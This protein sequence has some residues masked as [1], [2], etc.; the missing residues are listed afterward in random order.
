MLQNW[1]SK[2]TFEQK[3]W[4]SNLKWKVF[5]L[6]TVLM[7]HFCQPAVGFSVVF[8][9]NTRLLSSCSLSL[10]VL[11]VAVNHSSGWDDTDISLWKKNCPKVLQQEQR[12][13]AREA[14]GK[15][16]CL[17]NC[18]DTPLRI[19]SLCSSLRSFTTQKMNNIIFC[20][21]RTLDCSVDAQCAQKVFKYAESELRIFR[22]KKSLFFS[23]FYWFLCRHS[24]YFSIF[25]WF[26][27]RHRIIVNKFA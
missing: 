8:S 5:C 15:S 25:Y 3:N 18:N 21:K 24:C 19:I 11:M 7:G 2:L 13:K 27:L 10:N 9:H 6:R 22:K 12:S 16:L 17:P 14:K 26:L 23:L 4:F 20:P 1:K